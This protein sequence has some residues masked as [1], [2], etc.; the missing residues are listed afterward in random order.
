[1][2]LA[3]GLT[4]YLNTCPSL[5]LRIQPDLNTSM[6]AKEKKEEKYY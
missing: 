6:P 1:M 3:S 2:K 5:P 4:K